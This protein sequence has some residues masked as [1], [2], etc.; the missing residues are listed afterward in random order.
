[1]SKNTN[2]DNP[3]NRRIPQDFFKDFL[4]GYIACALWSSTDN[5]DESGGLPLDQDHD[6]EHLTASCY[7]RFVAD[8]ADFLQNIMNELSE[9]DLGRINPEHSG[10]DFWL[11][12]NG[13]GSGFWDRGEL[14]DG[15][16]GDRLSALCKPYGECSL[17]LCDNRIYCD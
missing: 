10:H 11:T 6:E 1:M 9:E 17:S 8:C 15:G 2:F 5:S 12:R 14:E 3:F 16:L 7:L 4:K 13:H